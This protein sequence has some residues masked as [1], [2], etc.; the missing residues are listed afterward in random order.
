MYN[1]IPGGLL[2]VIEAIA[3]AH[4]LEIVDAQLHQGRGRGLVRVI[5]DTPQGDGRVGVEECAAVSREI[6]H[7]LDAEDLMPGAYTLEVCSPGLDRT[8]GREKDFE[9]VV[10]RR[11]EIETREP[12]S[13]RRRFRGELV[14]FDGSSAHVH[15]E[16]G[17][18]AI[19]F[20]SIERARAF[21]PDPAFIKR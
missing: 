20:K 12:L 8:L 19:P 5:L 2:N 11:V 4:A 9:R 18:F 21:D 17:A 16:A 7:S 15:T 14:S 6:G 10:G 13:G 3:G 1:D